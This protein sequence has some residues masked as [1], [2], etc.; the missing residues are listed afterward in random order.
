MDG[1][2]QRIKSPLDENNNNEKE[3]LLLKLNPLLILQ[4][5]TQAELWTYK[6]THIIWI[7]RQYKRMYLMKLV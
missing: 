4:V 1:C 6:L 5:K 7:F 2:L 3:V